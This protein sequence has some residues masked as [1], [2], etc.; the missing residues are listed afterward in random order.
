MTPALRLA[1]SV[2]AVGAG[3]LLA[4]VLGLDD[5][6]A[7]PFYMTAV[8]TLLAVG[9]YG[10]ASGIP[11]EALRDVRR[12]VVAVTVGVLLKAL[13]I[14]GAMYVFHPHPASLLLGVAVA[15]IDP[16]SV[17]AMTR[18]S[19][20]SRRAKALLLAWASFDDP[21]T[22]LLTVYL[23]VFALRGMAE[24]AVTSPLDGEV[25]GYVADL[26]LN[27]L[28][29]AGG[30]VIWRL[31]K[32]WNPAP[33][34][35]RAVSVVLLV[36]LIAVA[37]WQFLIL[38]VALLGLFYRPPLGAALDRLITAA[39]YLAAFAL[40]ML[41]LGGVDLAAG[42]VLGGAAFL[43]QVL[44]GGVLIA[45]RRMGVTDRVYLALGQQNGLTAIVLV[46]SLQPA[47]PQAIAAVAPAILLVNVLHLVLNG[48]W[49]MRERIPGWLLRVRDSRERPGLARVARVTGVTHVAE[50]ASERLE[51]A[52]EKESGDSREW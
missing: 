29:A 14:A 7:S 51:T 23:S 49:D 34:V 9:L 3:L 4:L 28:F 6:P 22:A 37:V 11:A 38:G 45:P 13:L 2:C 30:W 42:A 41:L 26:G 17:A 8:S 24:G 16:L 31:L 32:K 15:Q 47:F 19:Q 1:A 27:V 40:G 25:G 5:V 33:A 43:A 46:L 52:L 10:S 18:N 44:V 21:I 50:R 20:M 12:V 39:F 48:V 35:F 36:A